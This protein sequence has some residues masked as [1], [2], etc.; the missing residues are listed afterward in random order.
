[1]ARTRIGRVAGELFGYVALFQRAPEDQR[2]SLPALR[3][4]VLSL[5]DAFSRDPRLQQLP[6]AEV[7][8][9]RFALVAWVDEVVLR[10]DWSGR[11]VWEREP[12][13]LQLF[14]TNRA[15]DQFYEHLERLPPDLLAAREIYFLCLAMGFEGAYVGRE[16][17]R[18]ALMLRQ[19]EML[20]VSGCALEVSGEE[21]LCPAVYDGLAIQLPRS[22]GGRLWSRLFAM[23][24]VCAALLGVC[25]TALHFYA[26]SV[27]LPPGS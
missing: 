23:A 3:S 22:S 7:E 2:P 18:H 11:D 24:L 9:A 26:G 8:E 12:L 15:G 16:A 20:R 14:A 10:S 21:Y 6:P 4:H 13:Q 25:W 1:M 17:D 19:Y 5:L 27:P